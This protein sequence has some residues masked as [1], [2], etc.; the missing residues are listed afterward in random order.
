MMFY[1][2]GFK[3]YTEYLASDHFQKL[4]ADIKRKW[5]YSYFCLICDCTDR[6]NLHHENYA[7]IPK[8][9][10]LKGDVIWLCSPECSCG[11]SCHFANHTLDSGRR[12]PLSKRSLSMRRKTLRA[13]YLKSS[14]R[15]STYLH[16]IIRWVYRLFW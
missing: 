14:V 7:S 13:R 4:R 3:T 9:S 1:E 15:P 16:F 11:R 8:E 6:M 10:F 12:L 5:P 2:L